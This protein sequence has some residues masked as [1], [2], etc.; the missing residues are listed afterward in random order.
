MVENNNEFMKVDGNSVWKPC[1]AAVKRGAASPQSKF[2]LHCG[3]IQILKFVP[4]L[5][6]RTL[7]SI[8]KN[9]FYLF[10]FGT[11]LHSPKRLIEEG[12]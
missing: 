11:V 10:L 1:V 6:C 12:I 2:L 5:V 4:N 9:D 7:Y 3:E 8:H